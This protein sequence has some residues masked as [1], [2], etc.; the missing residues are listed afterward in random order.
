MNTEADST[1]KL[2]EKHVIIEIHNAGNKTTDGWTLYVLEIERVINKNATVI[3][4]FSGS[5][6]PKSW[7]S[8]TW[9]CTSPTSELAHL[10]E[11]IKDI[12]ERFN[13]GPI[14]WIEGSSEFI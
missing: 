1:S 9:I 6:N 2:I 8:M 4:F 12:R 10:K 14:A 3:H 5:T 11:S 7:Q 13:Q